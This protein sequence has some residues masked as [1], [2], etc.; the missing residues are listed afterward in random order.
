MK[1]FIY[2]HYRHIHSMEGKS[3]E[4]NAH[5]MYG[6]FQRHSPSIKTDIKRYGCYCSSVPIL[7]IQEQN[8]LIK[9]DI[10]HFVI[11]NIIH[12]KQMCRVTYGLH[13]DVLFCFQA[14]FQ[15]KIFLKIFY[16]KT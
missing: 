15:L 3:G 12:T 4:E 8:D 2:S 9:D 16:L 6:T 1:L 10:C 13:E 5:V 7:S 11:Y 14:I